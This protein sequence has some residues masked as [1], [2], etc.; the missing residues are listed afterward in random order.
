MTKIK[1]KCT[2]V[3]GPYKGYCGKA[4]YDREANTFHG[5]VVG[6]RD[7]VTF[8][9][10]TPAELRKAFRGSV[11]D[12]LDFCASR[13]ES[14]EKPFSGK[15]MTRINPELHRTLAAMA[16]LADKSLN[17][18]ICDHLQAIADDALPAKKPK[19]PRKKRR[20]SRKV[21]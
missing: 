2:Y 17:Q 7:V 6:V 10:R 13:K 21:A 9:G 15:F 16:E 12:Y 4:Q 19:P 14:P 18:F 8:E 5:E 3:C 11:D 20:T 1:E